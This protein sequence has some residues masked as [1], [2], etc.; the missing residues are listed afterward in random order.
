MARWFT[1]AVILMVMIGGASASPACKGVGSTTAK[2]LDF[3]N[4]DNDTLMGLTIA[5]V[6]GLD[7]STF[8]ARDI[9]AEASPCKRGDFDVGSVTYSLYGDEGLP[10]RWATDPN[11]SGRLVYIAL[12]PRPGPALAAYR[13]QPNSS[14]VQF[15]PGDMMFVLAV[16][17]GDQRRL[18]R[19]YDAIPDDSTLEADMC[20][21]LSGQLALLGQFD[22]SSG[23]ADFAGLANSETPPA[24]GTCHAKVS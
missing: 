3:A 19:F 16:T 18:F 5:L 13:A 20:A 17:D 10:Q 11:L 21:A 7:P 15:K 6:Y 14:S 4:S 8:P 12:L 1:T 9:A 23:H 24:A 22:T 2:P